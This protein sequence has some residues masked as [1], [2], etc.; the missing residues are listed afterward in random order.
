MRWSVFI[1][2][3]LLFAGL[4]GSFMGLFAVGGVAP[5]LAPLL[6][7][8]VA[9]H[10]PRLTAMWAAIVVGLLADLSTP[11]VD[12]AL[13]PLHLLGPSSLGYLF[14][15]NLVLP[16]RS[17]VVRRNPLTLLVLTLLATFACGLVV[18]AIWTVRSFF[19]ESIAPF[20]SGS[21]LG[22]VAIAAWRAALCG[23]VALPVGWLMMRA[24]G[25]W[26]FQ[27]SGSRMMRW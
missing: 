24:V 13:R 8:F 4:D 22:D 5:L 14:A 6:V 20:A 19:G 18:T 26:A 9:M 27:G 10:A 12:A 23:A 3:L 21:P 15:V 17:M 7:V 2:F 1:V 11:A 25:L 16:L